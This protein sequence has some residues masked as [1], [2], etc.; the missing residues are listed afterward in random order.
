MGL[1]IRRADPG[2][3]VIADR[4]TSVGL[5]EVPQHLWRTKD[6]RLVE[7]GHV[8]A[9]QLAYARG[10]QIPIEK[11]VAEGLV[12]IE[13]LPSHD[14]PTYPPDAAATEPPAP[15][16]TPPARKRASATS[17]S[18]PPPEGAGDA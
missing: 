5:Y 16:A 7:S 4:G 14:V 3:L 10:D 13:A 9:E 18:K 11:A 15:P 8:A 1:E 12:P 2:R 6:G 17:R